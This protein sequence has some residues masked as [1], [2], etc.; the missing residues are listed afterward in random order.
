MGDRVAP[1]GT[2]KDSLGASL[3]TPVNRSMIQGREETLVT[4]K[5]AG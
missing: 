5:N 4:N 3:G 1:V 2:G